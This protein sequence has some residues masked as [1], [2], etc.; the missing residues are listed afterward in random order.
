MKTNQS[1]H[2]KICKNQDFKASKKYIA[3]RNRKK[4]DIAAVWGRHYTGNSDK[5]SSHVVGKI[6]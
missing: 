3:S 4:L 1:D 6:L 2:K 5:E